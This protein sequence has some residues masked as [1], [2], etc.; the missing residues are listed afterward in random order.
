M[1]RQPPRFWYVPEQTI[2]NAITFMDSAIKHGAVDGKQ[3]LAFGQTREILEASL[4]GAFSSEQQEK[5][6]QAVKK[7]SGGVSKPTHPIIEEVDEEEKK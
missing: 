4:T 2:H 5:Q 7:Q 1:A 3:A 6:R